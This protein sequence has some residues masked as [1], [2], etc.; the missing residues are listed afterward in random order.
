M[1]CG[2]YAVQPWARW[3]EKIT[4][5]LSY[6]GQPIGGGGGVVLTTVIYE[7]LIIKQKY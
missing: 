3:T 2:Q 6:H 5:H 4:K 1:A 7:P